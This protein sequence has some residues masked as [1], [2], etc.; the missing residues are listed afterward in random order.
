MQRVCAFMLVC[1]MLGAC[2][3]EECSGKCQLTNVL[4]YVANWQNVVETELLT[5][6]TVS[7]EIIGRLAKPAPTL[8]SAW[9]ISTDGRILVQAKD[10]NV[11]AVYIPVKAGNTFYWTCFGAP[12]SA[13]EKGDEIT[14]F[15][16]CAATTR[17]A[18]KKI[19]K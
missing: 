4:F 2:T 11:F 17:D 13:F 1:L 15:N 12:S 5:K 3:A 9:E 7:K 16:S 14:P 18:Q 8:V 6:G 10:K 19:N